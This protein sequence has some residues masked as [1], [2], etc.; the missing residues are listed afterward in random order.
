MSRP[1]NQNND[2]AITHRLHEHRAPHNV[3][4]AASSSSSDPV[5]L[6]RVLLGSRNSVE[7]SSSTR[8]SLRDLHL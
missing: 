1:E 4:L 5:L 6:L 3:E 2:I 8:P 7:S